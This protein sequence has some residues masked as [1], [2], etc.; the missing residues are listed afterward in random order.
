MKLYFSIILTCF[1]FSAFAQK[2]VVPATSSPLSGIS[3]PAGSKQD[4]RGI[5][6]S[7]AR[8]LLNEESKKM[9]S[10]IGDVEVFVLPSEK[11]SGYS[12]D[13]LINSLEEAGWEISILPDDNKY[14]WLRKGNEFLITYFNTDKNSTSLYFG[15]PKS[16]PLFETSTANTNNSAVQPVARKKSTVQVNTTAQNVAPGNFAFYITNWDDGW[17]STIQSDKVVVTKGN[18]KV[19][20]YFPL[21]HN[22]ETRRE[23]RDYFWDNYIARQ[24]K[25]I[26]K[27]YQDKGEVIGSLK[28]PYIEGQ[29]ID[30]ATGK[31]CFLGFYVTSGSGIMYPTLVVAPDANTLWANFPNANDNYNSEIAA[32]RGYNKFAIALKDLV[33]VWSGND[34]SAMNYYN[35]YT[36][37][38]LGMSVAA[39]SDEFTFSAD[40][41]YSSKHSGAT[42][43]V[44]NMQTYSQNYKGKATVSDWEIVLPN[45]FE[46]KTSTYYAYFEV[47]PGGR[48][49]HLQDKQ[50]KGMT[51]VLVK[52]Q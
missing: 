23:G 21:Q 27:Q 40:G 32:M 44:G 28:P 35:A 30:P 33:G 37:T 31:N 4:T 38:Y 29:A 45:R 50:Y 14:A 42:G 9:E 8:I 36:G 25:I 41:T 20:I 43:M 48:V 17:V 2:N 22:D 11:A 13:D 39:S 1:F 6:V 10:T 34:G 12:S 26:S 5:S 15:R 51:Y 7:A 47:I 49:L 18:V 24:F 52:K 19:Y 46:G 16:L 3:L